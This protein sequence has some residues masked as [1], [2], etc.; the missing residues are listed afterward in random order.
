[1]DAARV[2]KQLRALDERS[3]GRRVA[4]SETWAAERERLCR[5]VSSEL[6]GAEID[7]DQAGNIW[8][9]LPG[10]LPGTVVAGSHVDCVPEGGWLDGCLGVL[11][12]V[13]AARELAAEPAAERAT[14]AVVDWADEEGAL[15]GHSLLGSSAATGALDLERV[16]AMTTTD[17][18]AFT[19]LLR[20]NGI[21]PGQMTAASA[22]LEGAS[23]Y[24]ELHIEQ[25]PVLEAAGRACSAVS[26][27][28]GVV[29]LQIR[30]GGTA[31]H[32]G[33]A[34]MAMRQDPTLAAAQFVL[35]AR[36]AAVAAD[37]RATIG[38]LRAQ[39]GTPTAV[40]AAVDLIADLRHQDTAALERLAA[41]VATLAQNAAATTGCTVAYE[42]TFSVDPVE[43]DA[44][45]V[46]RAV[47]LTDGEPIISGALHD[48]TAV[49]KVG[50][51]TAMVF[52][53]T[54]DGISHSRAE[55]AAEADL[56][57]AIDAF[58]TL[59]GE[60]VRGA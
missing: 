54:R 13:E 5:E 34:P 48:A 10:E 12:A 14:L 46:A 24:L 45:L 42:P 1:M 26:G 41:E 50:I 44:G 19:E 15:T 27:C 38:T 9:R 52:V 6:P 3:G 55:D 22:R 21:D 40:A 53:R 4:W 39:P 60:L 17:G 16:R 23:A 36:D 30:F 8:M 11:A 35:A 2:I 25:G 49:A 7:R 32:A 51:P 33:A 31:A 56:S 57:R 20:A 29:R 43:F 28:L 18:V 59:V 58:G 47:E 37:G